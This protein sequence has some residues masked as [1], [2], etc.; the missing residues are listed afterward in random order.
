MDLE[1]SARNG[2]PADGSN[3]VWSF[4]MLRAAPF[5]GPWQFRLDC[6]QGTSIEIWTVLGQNDTSG[7]WDGTLTGIPA[8]IPG[9]RFF[10]Q[11]GS[12]N[13]QTGALALAGTS[14]ITIP[15]PG[16]SVI[17]VA[18]IAN[19]ADRAAASGTVSFSV[20]ITLFF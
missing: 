7:N 20:P 12:A 15:P 9:Q 6:T 4:L 17:P 18:R 2:V 13:L 11:V 14:A 1:I 8:I 5:T 10:L 3:S 16:P 19:G